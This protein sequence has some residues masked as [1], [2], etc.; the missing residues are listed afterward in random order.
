MPW[1]EPLSAA[2]AAALAAGEVL[3]QHWGR[4]SNITEKSPGNLCQ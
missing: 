4:L 2:T 1:Q 3:R